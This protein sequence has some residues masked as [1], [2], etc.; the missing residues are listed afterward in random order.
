M[1]DGTTRQVILWRHGRTSWNL[2]GRVQGQSD[3]DLDD[4]GRAQAR[5]AASRLAALAPD[6]IV[7]SDLKRARDTAQALSDITGQPLTLDPRLREMNFGQREGMTW[8]EA[9]DAFPEGMRAWVNGDETKIPGSETHRQAGERFAAGL[10]DALLDLPAGGALVV[11]AHGAVL[12]TGACVFLDFPESHWSTL[13][14][15]GNCSWSVLRRT[16]TNP[17]PNGV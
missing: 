3:T 5:S 2:A 12:R 8:R 10:R 7:S 11:V 15:L 6:R 1:T 14:G 17:G 4:V 16:P 13:G 9:W